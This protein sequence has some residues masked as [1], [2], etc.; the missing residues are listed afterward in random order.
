VTFTGFPSTFTSNVCQ[1]AGVLLENGS[2]P[3]ER[4]LKRLCRD[5]Q[6][7]DECARK[8]AAGDGVHGRR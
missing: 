2:I 6:P 7:D 3:V 8:R 4:S 5:E 1:P